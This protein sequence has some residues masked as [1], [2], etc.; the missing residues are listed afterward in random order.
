M[1][2]RL[3]FQA[4]ALLWPLA[5]GAQ[6]IQQSGSVTAGHAGYFVS[7]GILGDAG[8]AS[9][10]KLNTLGIRSTSTQA[11]G[12]NNALET[13]AHNRL[14]MGTTGAAAIIGL[15][16]YN[17]ATALPL[18]F[19]IH[20][21]TYTFPDGFSGTALNVQS[22]ASYT[23]LAS[24][25]AKWVVLTNAGAVAVSIPAAT[26]ATF[27]TPWATNLVSAASGTI[28]VTPVAGTICGAA[29]L[30]IPTNTSVQVASDS[31]NWRCSW[32]PGALAPL[33]VGTGLA[34]SGGN[35]NLAVPV[36][37]SSGG[38]GLTAGTSGGV[39]AYTAAGTL[40]S[41]GALTA[42]LPVI[43]GQRTR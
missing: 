10:A 2:F 39:L 41:S 7:T 16:A 5:L 19:S 17:G 21:T 37:V 22:G 8:T 43:G 15:N 28:T 12:I 14:S 33:N 3:L 25:K 1:I 35:L 4:L 13:G 29:T 38:T 30:T 9:S 31:T 20:G 36:A 34:S 11:F 32:I 42:N 18:Q 24:D 27:A 26:G 23:V 40:A 6:T